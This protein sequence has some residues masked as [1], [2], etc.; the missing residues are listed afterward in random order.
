M[1]SGIKVGLSFETEKIVNLQD[2]ATHYGSGMVDVFATPAMIALMEKTALECVNHIL[3]EG[4][5][6]VGT[7]IHIHHIKATPIGNKVKCKALVTE[8]DRRK[9]VFEVIAEDESGKIGFGTHTRFIIDQDEF[10]GQYT[11]VSRK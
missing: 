1:F 2:S 11:V 4:Y 6:T 10:S 7:E 8:V 9:I 5:T 3:P